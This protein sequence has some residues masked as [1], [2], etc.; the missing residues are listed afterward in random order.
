MNPILIG[1]FDHGNINDYSY[2]VYI[3][4]HLYTWLKRFLA[5]RAIEGP[6]HDGEALAIGK[7]VRA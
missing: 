7:T 2:T 4:I 5:T 3:C 1:G 6:C